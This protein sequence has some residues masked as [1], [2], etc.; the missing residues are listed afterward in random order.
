M[1]VD[2]LRISQ[3]PAW[4]DNFLPGSGIAPM[5]IAGVTY[6]V[7]A[8]LFGVQLEVGNVPPPVPSN[9]GGRKLYLYTDETDLPN[10]NLQGYQVL[11]M[12][13]APDYDLW[14]P[15]DGF[16]WSDDTPNGNI[17]GFFRFQRHYQVISGGSGAEG[18]NLWLCFTPGDEATSTWTM[19]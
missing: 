18:I 4:G 3:L 16:S 17:I 5:S 10:G 15:I 14:K 2:P 9:A 13:A 11:F 19:V 8:D 6:K 1:A 7:P 12:T